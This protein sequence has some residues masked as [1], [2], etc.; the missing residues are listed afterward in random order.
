MALVFALFT[1][2]QMN[3]LN[4]YKTEKWYLWVG[5][6]ALCSVISAASYFRRLPMMIYLSLAVAALVAAAVRLQGIEWE[7]AVL[8][9]ENNPSGN[10]TGGLLV[11]AIW[12][13]LLIWLRKDTKVRNADS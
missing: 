11:V 2:W 1:Y 12:M 7:K 8:Y 10:E 13:I 4:Q 9:N 5:A 6:Y 3:D